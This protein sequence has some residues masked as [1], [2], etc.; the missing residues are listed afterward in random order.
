MSAPSPLGMEPLFFLKV[1]DY[2]LTS[3][4]IV[5]IDIAELNPEFDTNGMTANLAAKIIDSI[6]YNFYH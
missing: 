1:L 3:K 2:L 6:V 4:K 5:G